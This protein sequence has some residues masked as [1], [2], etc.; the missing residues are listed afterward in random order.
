MGTL[1]RG[2][3]LPPEAVGTR[4]YPAFIVSSSV[5][6]PPEYSVE[7][8]TCPHCGTL[9]QVQWTTARAQGEVAY[10]SARCVVCGEITVWLGRAQMLGVYTELLNPILIYPIVT[11]PPPEPD[12]P[13]DAKKAYEEARAIVGVSPRGAGALVRLALEFLLRDLGVNPRATPAVA[14]AGL[15]E[16]GLRRETAMLLHTIR[17]RSND[18]VH[19]EVR[20]DGADTQE[21]ILL[22]ME[23]LNMVTRE[24]ITEPRK[25]LE[26]MDTLTDDQREL[27]GLPPKARDTSDE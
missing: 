25:R 8:F 23:L 4:R 10:R 9:A 2:R 15:E 12:M 7:A 6:K 26:A 22:N 24:L 13:E 20:T 5:F 27:I 11:G 14:I 19:P 18:A 16:R 1:S 3:D 21:G 17:F